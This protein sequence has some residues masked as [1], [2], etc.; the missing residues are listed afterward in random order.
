MSLRP[1]KSSNVRRCDTIQHT[2]STQ[3][4]KIFAQYTIPVGRR[5]DNQSAYSAGPAQNLSQRRSG[6][7]QIMPAAPAPPAMTSAF[8]ENDL[9]RAPPGTDRGQNQDRLRRG[10]GSRKSLAVRGFYGAGGGR[11]IYKDRDRSMLLQMGNQLPSARK[12]KVVLF[13]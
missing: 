5:T 11:R 9:R 12:M 3:F 1:A 7:C 2:F 6:S 4:A 8:Q 10:A 13:I